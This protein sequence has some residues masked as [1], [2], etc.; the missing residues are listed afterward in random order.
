MLILLS[1]F[2]AIRLQLNLQKTTELIP[3]QLI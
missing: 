3:I 2:D 1:E